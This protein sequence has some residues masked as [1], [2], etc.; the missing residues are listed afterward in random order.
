MAELIEITFVM[1]ADIPVEDIPSAAAKVAL[2]INDISRREIYACL[3][4]ADVETD[5]EMGV[6]IMEGDGVGSFRERQVTM[7]LVVR[8]DNPVSSEQIERLRQVLIEKPVAI[9][10]D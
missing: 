8:E 10:L 1:P 9:D 4:I 2:C 3:R 7:R 5:G 6:E